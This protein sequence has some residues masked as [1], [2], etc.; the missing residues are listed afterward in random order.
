MEIVK[1]I[2]IYGFL[3]I[4]FYVAYLFYDK[5]WRISIGLLI[6]GIIATISVIS[7]DIECRRKEAGLIKWPP[8]W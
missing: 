5:N 6:I 8:R 1:H 4:I 2:G 3:A 7:N